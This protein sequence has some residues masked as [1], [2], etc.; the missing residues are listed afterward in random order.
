MHNRTYNRPV[1]Y[2]WDPAKAD[3]N[4]RKHKIHFADAVAVF[5][6]DSAVTIEDDHEEENRFVTLGMEAFARILVFCTWRGEDIRLISA[7]LPS[8]SNI[9]GAYEKAIRF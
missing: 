6:D 1:T 4:F 3:A 2:E 7:R 8:E 5:S 9:C